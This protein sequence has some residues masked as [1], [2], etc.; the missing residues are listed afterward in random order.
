MHPL[1]LIIDDILVIL[2]VRVVGDEVLLDKDDECLLDDVL[3]E[4]YVVAD[5]VDWKPA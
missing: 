5:L 3:V 1:T 4:L 2:E